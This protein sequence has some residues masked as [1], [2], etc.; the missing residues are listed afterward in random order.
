MA[1]ATRAQRY[2][3]GGPPRQNT[4]RAPSAPP[5]SAPAPDVQ[6]DGRVVFRLA[7]KDTTAVAV[8]IAGATH[9]MRKDAG[10]VWTATVG[11]LAPEISEYWFLVHGVRVLDGQNKRVKPGDFSASLLEIPANPPRFDQVQDV[12]HGTLELVTYRSTPF[13]KRRDLYV[14]LPPQYRTERTR[15]FPVLYLRHRER[16]YG[17]IMA[18]PRTCWCRSGEPDRAA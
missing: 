6:A 18:V 5:P 15:R 8:R 2:V 17:T 10:G 4:F 12:P 7:A 11:P 13:D 3:S 16:R 9:S 14:F 1:N